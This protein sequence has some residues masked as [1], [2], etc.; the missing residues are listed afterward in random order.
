MR[1]DAAV[2]LAA[3]AVAGLGVPAAAPAAWVTAPAVS[4]AARPTAP[5]VA[6]GVLLSPS[7]AVSGGTPAPLVSG[8]AA[9]GS[10]IPRPD[11]RPVARRL[12]LTPRNVVASAALPQ[13]RFRVRQRGIYRVRARVVVVRLPSHR[14]VAQIVLGWVR[15]GRR[16]AVRWPRGVRLRP[17]RYVVRLHAKD[18][19]GHTLARSARYP[20]RARIVVHAPK[21]VA[22]PHAAPAPAP[23]V[24]LMP[25]PAPSPA[26]PGVFPVAGPFGFGRADARFGAGRPGH[27]HEGQDIIAASGTPVVAPYAGIV[28]R[29][30]YQAAGAGEYVVLDAADGRDYFFAHCIRRSTAVT[31]GA[32]VSAGQQLCQVGSSGTASGPHLH[33][34]IWN[35]G[36]RIPGGYPID[37]LP[38]LR[39]WAGI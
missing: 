29:T 32:A 27:L 34:E 6:G 28:S 38:E 9:Y 17:G 8:G 23:A 14:P 24:P 10:P 25:A 31:E 35:V 21:K 3:V 16:V 13:I 26:G 5:S 36:W 15:P 2:A 33:F 39:A 37:A 11:A 7:P 1:M 20:G 22:P 30:S 4:P 19:R 18:G 12:T